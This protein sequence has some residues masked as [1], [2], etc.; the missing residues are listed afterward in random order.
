MRNYEAIEYVLSKFEDGTYRHEDGKI[1][2]GDREVKG[3]KVGKGKYLSFNVTLNGSKV[4]PRF[5]NIIYALEHG[6]EE[7]KKHETI[8]HVDGDKYN[9]R[10]ENL[11][12]CTSLDNSRRWYL[13]YYDRVAPF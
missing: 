2:R 4:N 5:H 10:I 1:F 9:N 12:G 7:L 11:E 6:I 8:D 13:R 3:T